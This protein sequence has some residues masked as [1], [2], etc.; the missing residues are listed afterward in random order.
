M[1]PT[2]WVILAVVAIVGVVV[3]ARTFIAASKAKAEAE[4][5]R[6]HEQSLREVPLTCRTHGHAYQQHATGWRCVACGNYL[7]QSEGESYGLVRE[8]RIDRRREPR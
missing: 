8:G 3:G 6:A 4:A 2:L 5:R 7:S 1:T